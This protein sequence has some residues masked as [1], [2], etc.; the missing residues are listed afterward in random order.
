MFYRQLGQT[1]LQLSA[2]GLGTVKFGRNQGVKYPS[3]FEL[4]S[5]I[6]ARALMNLARDLGINCLD[7]APAYGSSEERLGKLLKDDRKHWHIVSKVGEEFENGES[8]FN[9]SPEHIRMSVER[10]LRRLKTDY[11]D[12][13]M[14]H[15][16]GRDVEIIERDGA[17]ETLAQLKQ[18]G[19]IR[20]FGMSTKTVA[21]GIMAARYSD[22]VMVTYN[23]R[24][25]AEREVLDYCAEHGKGALIKKAFAS[26]HLTDGDA[27][28]EA[29]A[30]IFSHP[31]ATS[32]VVGT[33]NPKHLRENVAKLPRQ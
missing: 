3:Q 28:A 31:G 29:L 16:D 4:P 20:S 8:S 24:E 25:Q 30:M 5:D 33:L 23:L 11:I 12:C 26:G 14:V 17:L 6:D 9:F 21:G 10:S 15:S 22:C 1:D 13:V 32:A 7:T 27:V 2:L 19:W 18:K